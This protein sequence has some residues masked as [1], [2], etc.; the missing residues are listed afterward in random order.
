MTPIMKQ[1]LLYAFRS[2][3]HGSPETNRNAQI[4]KIWLHVIK[5]IY[6]ADICQ[7]LHITIC[8]QHGFSG[9]YLP[10]SSTTASHQ[11]WFSFFV[12]LY[13]SFFLLCFIPCIFSLLFFFY[14]SLIS[15][16]QYVCW[17]S[18]RFSLFILSL[19][20]FPKFIFFYLHKDISRIFSSLY[21]HMIL[22]KSW[23][24]GI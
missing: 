19:F 12:L 9:S 16:F 3:R 20:L 6:P 18:S 7:Q 23:F 14:T 1:K 4:L 24:I 22:S 21:D 15:R 11:S 8:F 13:A 5:Q 2:N 17:E 10:W